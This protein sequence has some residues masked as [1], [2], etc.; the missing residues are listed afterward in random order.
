MLLEMQPGAA[1]EVT[2]YLQALC[3]LDTGGIEAVRELGSRWGETDLLDPC[4]AGRMQACLDKVGGTPPERS[5][6]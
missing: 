3:S 5:W 4:A 6:E 1:E 2:H